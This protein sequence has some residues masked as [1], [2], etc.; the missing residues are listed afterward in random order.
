MVLFDFIFDPAFLL[1]TTHHIEPFQNTD[2]QMQLNYEMIIILI[3]SDTWTQ[4][5][6]HALGIIH[7]GVKI[8]LIKQNANSSLMGFEIHFW[9]RADAAVL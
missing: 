9:I 1:I 4:P 8:F 2:G 6:L 5:P 3:I 7:I